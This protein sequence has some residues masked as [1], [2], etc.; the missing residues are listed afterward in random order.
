[1]NKN[2]LI[3]SILL[4]I[5]FT[6]LLFSQSREVT[7]TLRIN[8]KNVYKISQRNII[9]FSERVWVGKKLIARKDYDADFSTG[10]FKLKPSL[11]YSLLDTLIITYSSIK[12]NLKEEYKHRS[13]EIRLDEKTLDTLRF[14]KPRNTILTS[15][16]IFGNN[17]Q[18][19]GALVRGFTIG[20][21]RDF[22]LN[23]G[24]RLQLTGKLSEDI[25][26]VAALSDENTPIQPE[27]NTETLDE[28]DKVFIELKH[29]NAVG[30]F[31]D[32]ELNIR[33]TEFAQI[34]RKLQGLKGEVLF[35]ST[36]G[37]VA[38]AASRGKYN[39]NLIQGQDGNQGPYRL[40]GINN[41]R[42]IIVIAGSE[43]VFVDGV[44]MKRGENNDYVIDYSNAEVTFS[45]K[46]LITSASR[47]TIE[48]EYT[49]QK[50]KRNFLGADFETRFIDDKLKIGVS[51]F[52]EGDDE[53]SAIDFSYSDEQR[54]I[55]KQAGN[56]RNKAV[57]S[58][59]SIAPLDSLGKTQG[60]FAKVDTTINQRSFTYYKY[61]PN[62]PASIYNVSFTYVGDGSGDYIKESLGVYKFVGIGSGAYLPIVY[63]PMPEQKQ[64]GNISLSYLISKGISISAE[65]SASSWDKN[66]ISEIDDSQNL[67]YARKVNFNLE[68]QEITVADLS[69]GKIGLSYKDRLIQSKYSSLDRIDDVEF[70]RNYNISAAGGDQVLREVQLS[71]EPAKGLN[72]LSQY[73]FLMQGESFSS[74]RIVN[75]LNLTVPKLFTT[76]YTFDY[77]A[78]KNQLMESKWI[79][80]NG[81]SS[82][83]IGPVL[84]G[85]DFLHEDKS[86]SLVGSDSLSSTSLRYLEI[87]PFIQY[88]ASS[89]FDLKANIGFREESFPL[90]GIL[91]KQ[92]GA[93]THQYQLN[94][95]G[96]KEFTTSLNLTIRNKTY[97]E[98]FK[99][100]GFGNNETILLLS[101]SR[102]NLLNNFINGELFYQAATEQSA[103]LEKVFVK[104]PIGTGSYI[105]LGDLNNNGLP[106][107]NEF[108]LSLYEADFI[109]VTIPTDK[110]FPVIDLKTNMRWKFDFARIVESENFFGKMIKSISTETFW[111]VEENSKDPVTKD[112]YLL[113]FSKFLNETNTIRGSNYFQQDLN[114]FQNNSDLSF[115]VRY[116]QRRSLNQ[117]SGGVE[118]GFLR[119]RS[120]RI[121]FK[122]VEEINNQTDIINQ[123][124]NMVSPSST[125]RSREISKN[126]FVSDFSYRPI[127][128]M[129]VGFKFE[130]ARSLDQYPVKPSTVDLNSL[131]V[132]STYSFEN[133]GRLRVEFE[134]TELTSSSADYNIPF[135]VLRGNVI[136]KN[137]FGRVFFDFRISSL[138]QTSVSY[139]ARKLGAGRLIHTMRAEAKAYF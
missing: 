13:L 79:R 107:E 113:N 52:Q 110:L 99:R 10:I 26:L 59:V 30:T 20:T 130:V 131:V 34:T 40:S 11:N 66:K 2:S 114:L 56:D 17:L 92:S 101:Q 75:Q 62:N 8:L 77:V 51:Y 37:Q 116:N 100:L 134:R 76:H 129:E 103:R 137:Y 63:L 12:V 81:N 108:Q 98:E 19:S 5:I 45:A 57:I 70:N 50:F 95:R 42:T 73:G 41:E 43:K 120:L 125:G 68:P 119:E 97:T 105:Y 39:S 139:D 71:L 36:K 55:L 102:T 132:R 53:N 1:M 96:V 106:E 54:E 27:G 86:E 29:K 61:L 135:E 124:D 78:T 126:S 48:F 47:I 111:R 58:G 9:P 80:Q 64:L 94:Y 118:K 60:Y 6:S 3:L 44:A 136:G 14:A 49:D 109:V 31:G 33:N 123:A 133:I 72:I 65:L 28:L 69:L 84:S 82:F 87:A 21:N 18:K 25:E 23:S 16:S 74:N 85:V 22:T 32:Y 89:S 104:V 38:I 46:R 90:N 24:L 121:R 128:E 93:L 138:L 115:R 112:I 7:D 91:K 35:G 83:E 15:E 88:S 117:Y 4:Q 127:R 67:G 122:M